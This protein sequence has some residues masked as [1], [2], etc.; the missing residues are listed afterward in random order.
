LFAFVVIELS[1]RDFALLHSHAFTNLDEKWKLDMPANHH[2]LILDIFDMESILCNDADKACIPD[3]YEV[4]TE[5]FRAAKKRNEYSEESIIYPN[6]F[7]FRVQLSL[8]KMFTVIGLIDQTNLRPGLNI[9]ESILIDIEDMM[10]IDKLSKKTGLVAL[11]ISIENIKLWNKVISDP[12]HS[13]QELI[14][15]KNTSLESDEY[16]NQILSTLVKPAIFTA[17][18]LQLSSEEYRD[19]HLGL[20]LAPSITASAAVAFSDYF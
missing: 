19:N 16:D 15:Y 5:K 20:I 1:P 7:D 3:S 12:N 10:D 2:D 9:L 14:S 4:V 18:K 8:H 6:E 13:F 17:I 11:S